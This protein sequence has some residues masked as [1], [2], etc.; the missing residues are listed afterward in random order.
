MKIYAYDPATGTR[1]EVLDNVAC[2]SWGDSSVQ[3]NINMG[4]LKDLGWKSPQDRSN[5]THTMHID[6]GISGADGKAISYVRDDQWVTYCR[7]K[8]RYGINTPEIWEWTILPSRK[9]LEA[10]KIK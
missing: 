9:D 2:A 8:C 10:A 4:L 3:H 6:G 1:G 5:V 7:G